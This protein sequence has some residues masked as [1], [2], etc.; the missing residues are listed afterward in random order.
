MLVSNCIPGNCL[1]QVNPTQRNS[2]TLTM[3]KTVYNPLSFPSRS[4]I[5][6]YS[7]NQ[8]KL[9]T[10]EEINNL[11]REAQ[12]LKRIRE[13][14]GSEDFAEKVF[15]KVFKD[16]IERLRGMSDMWKTR[17]PPESLDYGTLQEQASDVDVTVSC[18]DQKVWTLEED[19]VVFR[20]R[21]ELLGTH[22]K[23]RVF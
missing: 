22:L 1:E 15:T 7:T 21:F 20:D 17:R 11:R 10:A 8:T 16:D 23:S 14:M 3:L 4:L 6:L 13:S 18:N 12:A 5:Q 2:I 9:S 19:F